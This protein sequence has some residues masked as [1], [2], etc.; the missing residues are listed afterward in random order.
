MLKKM[1]ILLTVVLLSACTY[2]DPRKDNSLT[3]SEQI[4]EIHTDEKVTDE[5]LIRYNLYENPYEYYEKKELEGTMDNTSGGGTMSDD[6]GKRVERERQIY[7]EL[8]RLEEV[9][10]A[11][12]SIRPQKITVAINLESRTE[13]EEAVEKVREVVENITGRTDIDVI[14]DGEHNNRIEDTD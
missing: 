3:N 11:G 4:T 13:P 12:V 10:Q 5:E 2:V 14:V 7:Y 9:R 6:T 8:V 1:L